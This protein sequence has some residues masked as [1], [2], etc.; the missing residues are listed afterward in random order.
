MLKAIHFLEVLKQCDEA[1]IR[2]QT[3][4]V[5][6][7]ELRTGD[8]T[9]LRGWT[10]I[11]HHWRKRILKFKNYSNG[12]IRAVRAITIKKFNNQQVYL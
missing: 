6:F 9:Q 3:V 11:A 4:D 2:Q 8:I 1:R 10:P 5:E 12:Q 7:W